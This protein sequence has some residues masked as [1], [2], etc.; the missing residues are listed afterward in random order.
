[1]KQ[2]F[3]LTVS[4]NGKKDTLEFLESGKKL[5]SFGLKINWVVVD[6]GSND[7]LVETL[8]SDW[9]EVQVVQVGENLGFTGGYNRGMKY[10]V[11]KGADY[12]FVANNDTVFAKN[13]ILTKLVET[14]DSNENIGVVA[15]KI[16]FAPGFEFFKE[17]Y[18]IGDRGKVIWYAGGEFDQDNLMSVHR[19]IDQV[20]IGQYNK[21]EEVEFISGCCFLVKRSVLKDIGYFDDKLFAYFEDSDWIMRV[22]SGGLKTMYDGRTGIYHKVSR[23][24]GIGSKIADYYIARNRLDFAVKYARFR[25]K[26]AILRESVWLLLFG[27]ELQKQGI[28]DFVMRRWGNI[29]IEKT[30]TPIWP[31]ELSVA[32]V[33][34]KTKDLIKQLLKSI[35]KGNRL[36]EVVVLDNGSNDGCGEMI[37]KE[38]PQTIFIQSYTN[39]GFSGGYNQ[40]I[41]ACRGKYVLMLNSDIEVRPGAL[42][43]LITTEKQ[44]GGE[45]VLSGKLILPDGSTQKS[46]FHLPTISGAIKEYFLQ[47]RDAFF[48][49]LPDTPDIVTAQKI[50]GA[51][52]ACLLIPRMVLN[53]VGLLSE[54]TKLY[55]EDVDYCKRLKVKGVPLFYVPT[56]VF[57][58]HH[59]AS[60]KKIGTIEARNRLILAS[61]WYHGIIYYSILR[62]VL[63]LGQKYDK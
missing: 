24:T 42:R 3:I 7:G 59:G 54:E 33:N 38:F 2:I 20:D 56:A 14:I 9:P 37:R 50:D 21:V 62:F 55:Y 46:A 25:T 30:G 32:I 58:H 41:N 19:G 29:R 6:N 36:T 11:S 15:P 22:R 44:L 31:I 60:S 61:K 57:D 12:I 48:S 1:M 52:M 34:Y 16:W 17:K 4:F 18:S 39:L 23:T 28:K 45:V 40:A 8:L 63:W 13:D 10:C 5:S 35:Y 53:K 26:L 51:V 27:R 43:S 47:K 49:Y